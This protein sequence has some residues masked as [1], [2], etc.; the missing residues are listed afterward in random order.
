MNN[1][2]QKKKNKQNKGRKNHGLTFLLLTIKDQ[3]KR[4][5]QNGHIWSTARGRTY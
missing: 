4:K 5:I 3:S 1:K 2:Y